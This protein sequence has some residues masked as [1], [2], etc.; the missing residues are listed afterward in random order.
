[1]RYLVIQKAFIGDVVLG[2]VVPQALRNLHPDAEIH[3]LVRNGTEG[4]LHGHPALN[5]VLV[6]NKQASKLRQLQHWR[7]FIVQQRYDAVLNLHRFGTS[8]VLTA[9]S[10]APVRIGFQKNP[11]SWAYTHRVEHRVGQRGDAHPL[12]EVDRNLLLVHALHPELTFTDAV[13]RMPKLYPQLAD[14]AAVA[15]Y[16]TEPY[17]VLAP[18][19]VWFTKQWPAERWRAVVQQLATQLHV[20]VT[21]APNEVELC[22]S[23]AQHIP[24]ATSLASQLTLAQTVALMAGAQRVYCNDSSPIHFAS[25]L[26]VPTT[27]VFCSTVPAFGFGP[28]AAG[29]TVVEDQ[30]NLPC[31]PCGLH[32]FR[33]C[34]KGHFKCAYGIL[35]EALL[36]R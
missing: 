23:V 4:F 3:Y 10:S 33:A 25:A 36:N 29:S 35:P 22:R 26:G 15:R 5:Q 32:G 19:S 31:R 17:A 11:F 27:A 18:A 12:H 14:C 6:W 13:W 2:L 7:S 8:G 9:L 34:P 16:T 24:N 28:L 1:V 20:Y 30:H 21:G